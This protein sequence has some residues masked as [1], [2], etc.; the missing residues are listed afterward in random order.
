[1]SP[2][3]SRNVL[4]LTPEQAAEIGVDLPPAGSAPR[5]EKPRG[6]WDGV[7][8]ARARQHQGAMSGPER[9][10][11]KELQADLEAGLI[12]GFHYDAVSFRLGNGLHYR[13]DFLVVQAD[14]LLV[15]EE[16]KGQGGWLNEKARPKWKAAGERYRWLRFRALVERPKGERT[17]E[18]LGRWHVEDYQPVGDFP[19]PGGEA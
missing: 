18:P 13:P 12:L 2:R 17:D 4:R 16:I 19:A 15:A 9:A 14:G 7:N 3:R 6:K 8:A 11:A 10:R 1:M 5:V